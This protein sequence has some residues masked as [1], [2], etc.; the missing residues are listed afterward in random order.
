[1][2]KAPRTLVSVSRDTQP[3]NMQ[4]SDCVR[5]ASGA[6]VSPIDEFEAS[7]RV[8]AKIAA[9]DGAGDKSSQDV[10]GEMVV[11]AAVASVESYFR[12]VLSLLAGVCP[13][14][15]ER[16]KGDTISFGA[17][18]S[19]PSNMLA[20]ASLER[21]LFSS[22]GVI[23][24][25]L[26]K[27][28][29]IQVKDNDELKAAV[30]AFEVACTCRHSMVHWR[31]GLDSETMHALGITE[32][33][34]KRYGLDPSFA[35]VQRVLASCVHVVGVA[36][37]TLFD[38]TLAKWSKANII[39]LDAVDNSED[40]DRLESLLGVFRSSSSHSHLT[41]QGLLE[42]LVDEPVMS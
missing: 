36:N 25:Q 34:S 35:L 26:Q 41:A 22:R 9:G 3:E 40:M 38:L 10:L 17:A 27:F 39:F 11:V 6:L 30:D 13:L 1:M 4:I 19:Y 32:L 14:T 42:T 20:L 28:I 7:I 21:T 37:K 18:M 24:Q 33:N 8:L 2:S 23:A 31:G 16:I 15:I 5:E 29:G 12:G